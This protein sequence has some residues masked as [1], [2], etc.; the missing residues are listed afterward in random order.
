MDNGSEVAC[1]DT[2]DALAATG[3]T[4][5]PWASRPAESHLIADDAVIPSASTAL[6][7][8]VNPLVLNR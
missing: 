7:S 6:G 4:G 8:E 3:L 5:R 1:I 2:G